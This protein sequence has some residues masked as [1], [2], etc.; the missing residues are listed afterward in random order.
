[1]KRFLVLFFAIAL[2]PASALA[3]DLGPPAYK[4]P[5][6]PPP[7]PPSWTGFYGG[8]GFGYGMWNADTGLVFAPTGD[9]LTATV[10]NGGRGWL[11]TIKLGYDYQ[12]SS[13]VA[14]AFADYNFSNVSG[15]LQTPTAICPTCNVGGNE[16][17]NSSWAV[18][19]RVG[20]LVT[21]DILSYWN[22]GYTE[23]HFDAINLVDQAGFT[24]QGT[25]PGTTYHG[26]FLG[27]GVETRVTFLPISGLFFF[28]EYRY[29]TY[30]KDSFPSFTVPT[31]NITI[32]PYTQTVVS[33]LTYKFNWT[34]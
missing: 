33:G 25:I 1:M 27:G 18:G 29:S 15:W 20:W 4:A 22:G 14:G 17:E 24:P 21:P 3:A 26:W 16:K 10:T 5:P 7:P 34:P 23:A 32:R 6:P 19:G 13:I 2:L 12:F 11:G 28:T 31:T 9:P 30:N 8:A